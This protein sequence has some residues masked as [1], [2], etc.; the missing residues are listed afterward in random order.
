MITQS[1]QYQTIC[2]N[3]LSQ[4]RDV[5]MNVANMAVKFSFTKS[6]DFAV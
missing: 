4:D 5:R 2:Y 6:G 1:I 3:L